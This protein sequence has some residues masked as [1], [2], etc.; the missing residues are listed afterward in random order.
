MDYSTV[1][2]LDNIT[3]QDCIDMYKMK[4]MITICN[5]GKVIGFG[6]EGEKNGK[7]CKI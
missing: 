7:T 2:E 5:D 1:I 4:N 3:I 6:K